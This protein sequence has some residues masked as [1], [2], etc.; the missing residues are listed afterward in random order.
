[1]RRSVRVIAG[2]AALCVTASFIG[3][4]SVGAQTPQGVGTSRA[5]HTLLSLQLGDA[6]SLLNL[7]LLA[8][9][10]Q[11][12]I[13]NAVAPSH[14]V[15]RLAPLSVT[16]S[17]IPA[18]NSITAA[19]P[20]FESR[21][22]GGNPDVKGSALDLGNPAGTGALPLNVLA[23][24]IVPASLTSALDAAGAR[25]ALDAALAR[26]SLLGLLKVNSVSNTL[27]TAAA[28]PAATGTRAL[29]IDAVSLLNL[30]DLLAGLNLNLEKL[31][32][33]VVNELVKSLNVPV[34]LPEGTG[35]LAGA[36]ATL[37]KAISDITTAVGG[38]NDTLDD[39]V[40]TV[41]PVS[42]VVSGLPVK[43]PVAP[44]KVIDTSV[45]QDVVVADALKTLQDTLTNLLGGALKS[46]NDITLLKLDGAKV[47]ATTKAADTLANSAADVVANLGGLTVLGLQL[48]G[49]DLLSVGNTLNAVTNQLTSVLGIID[50]SL[51]DLV[52]VAVLDKSTS[53]AAKDGYNEALAGIDVLSV[54]ITPPALLGN[55][56]SSLT[57]GG[58][59]S[60]RTLS[61]AGVAN[62]TAAL[63]VLGGNALALGGLLDLPATLGALTQGLT[64][65]LG[66]VQSASQQRITPAPAPAVLAAEPQAAPQL[67]RTGGDTRTLGALAAV[68]AALALGVRRWARRPL[69]D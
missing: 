35:D 53:V 6:G 42:D 44:T 56:V 18:L 24:S 64:L 21:T 10:A 49:V 63:P 47:A 32:L 60:V 5:S 34:A 7:S 30:G 58:N 28:L 17:A 50:P 20:T 69:E 68:M 57:G 27:G 52:K 41:E 51:K 23:G 39:V 54:K 11:S 48:P 3:A 8:D 13:D 29:S 25:S 2:A 1:M 38:A 43:L 66:T 45:L 22:P 16:S 26:L 15:S 55:L 65:K 46:L 9:T 61:A 19:L 33:S 31:D 40:K 36:V 62:P 59:S 4:G 67:P 37:T 12:T 14:A